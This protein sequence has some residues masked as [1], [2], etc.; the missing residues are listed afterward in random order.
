MPVWSDKGF[1]IVFFFKQHINC[2]CTRSS[3]LRHRS[4]YTATQHYL[5]RINYLICLLTPAYSNTMSRHFLF[6]TIFT[7][8]I[9]LFELCILCRRRG[10]K[11]CPLRL[12]KLFMNFQ[13]ALHFPTKVGIV[14]YYAICVKN[15]EINL[16]L[17]KKKWT[18]DIWMTI[19]EWLGWNRHSIFNPV[20]TG[21]SECL[22]RHVLSSN[23]MS[24]LQD[25]FYIFVCLFVV[26]E[27]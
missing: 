27:L 5:S 19:G 14:V 1:F 21:C 12:A 9:S 10:K 26:C 2:C 23:I 3:W 13:Q 16:F 6:L 15:R 24:K 8:S 20:R 7:Q 22:K 11:L 17:C 18:R 4:A 25:L